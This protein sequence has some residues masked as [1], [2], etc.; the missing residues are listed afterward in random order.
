MNL[1]YWDL[2]VPYY[3]TPAVYPPMRY[4]VRVFVPVTDLDDIK[5]YLQVATVEQDLG[6]VVRPVQVTDPVNPTFDGFDV[7]VMTDGLNLLVS[8][9]N[10][11]DSIGGSAARQADVTVSQDVINR[12][13]GAFT[14]YVV[15]GG[16]MQ[17]PVGES[18]VRYIRALIR[19]HNNAD[20]N[21]AILNAQAKL[22]ALATASYDVTAG[23]TLA[24]Q[25]SALVANRKERGVAG[26]MRLNRMVFGKVSLQA[27][28]YLKLEVA[29]LDGNPVAGAPVQTEFVYRNRTRRYEGKTN[30]SGARVFYKSPPATAVVWNFDTD[31]YYAPADRLLEI[32]FQHPDYKTQNCV[33]WSP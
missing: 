25:L 30:A 22:T 28:A 13:G 5:D 23:Q 9:A 7:S 4:P 24:D 11:K 2:M 26:L 21:A 15:D 14:S 27:A 32:H 31:Q 20:Y 10:V 19:P 33:T 8:V 1:N 29:D 6:A 16:S 3:T 12:F 18:D 17:L